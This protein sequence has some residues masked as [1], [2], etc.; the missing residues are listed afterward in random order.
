[1]SPVAQ[2]R[3]SVRAGVIASE[4]LQQHLLK[5]ALMHF[6]FQVVLATDP[7]RFADTGNDD[8]DLW[9]VDLNDDEG[10]ASLS[11]LDALFDG[12]APVLFGVG[13]APERNSDSYPRWEKRLYSKI[14]DLV[15]DLAL[16]TNDEQSLQQLIDAATPSSSPV[17]L[18]AV[19]HDIPS[20]EAAEH[21]WVLGASLGGPD[22]VK[23]FLDAL[24]AGLPAAFV[25]AQ[26]IDA[27]FQQTL[28]QTLGRHSALNMVPYEEGRCLRNGEVM[29]APVEHEF[30]FADGRTVSRN[31]EW[32]GPYGPSIDQVILNVARAFGD[33][34]RYII[35]SGMG[36]DGAEAI[37]TLAHNDVVIW[38][39]NPESCANSSMPES[40][41]ATGRVS[42]SGTPQ[43][44]AA[45]LV[46]YLQT[47]WVVVK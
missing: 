14:R 35:F 30:G 16:E 1:M 5:N 11:C 6:G 44:L 9:L 43:Q 17:S 39:Q 26:H 34:A 25:Y 47:Q 20:G 2:V 37:S 31:N 36:N 33:R 24:P 27:G 10:Q 12:E 32:P 13:K 42:Y 3:T 4:I 23:A 21:I 19:F 45:Q 15:N 46:N 18:P 28:I 8:V 40:A 38:A 41:V 7:E 29:V 22:A